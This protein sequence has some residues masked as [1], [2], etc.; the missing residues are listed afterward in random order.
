MLKKTFGISGGLM[1]VGLGAALFL[2]DVPASFADNSRVA[3]STAVDALKGEISAGRLDKFSARGGYSESEWLAPSGPDNLS[4]AV[5]ALRTGDQWKYLPEKILFARE[6]A[7]HRWDNVGGMPLIVRALNEGRGDNF[8]TAK[9]FANPDNFWNHE[10]DGKPF[11][12]Y[13]IVNHMIGKVDS[14]LFQRT[15]HT[16]WRDT[17]VEGVPL[18]GTIA[19]SKVLTKNFY[20]AHNWIGHTEEMKESYEWIAAWRQKNHESA[21]YKS[22]QKFFMEQERQ[23]FDRQYNEAVILTKDRENR[24]KKTQIKASA[25]PAPGM[26]GG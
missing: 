26:Y 3:F 11:A 9:D 5:L 2:G 16:Y 6:M 21:G 14:S 7:P 10:V 20:S 4:P 19:Q 25:A 17:Q 22:S 12:Y 15:P 13:L 1:A 18:Y 24:N 8:I 23:N